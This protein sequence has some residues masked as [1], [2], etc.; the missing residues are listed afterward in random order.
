MECEE[1]KMREGRAEAR[2]GREAE[3]R[4]RDGG[5]GDWGV[6]G[7]GGEGGRGAGREGWREGGRVGVRQRARFAGGA[8][9]EGEGGRVASR[10]VPR[11]VVD[12]RWL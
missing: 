8:R 2:G 6:S 9:E 1:V 11:W 3:K 5:E 7:G 12:A 10:S 4:A